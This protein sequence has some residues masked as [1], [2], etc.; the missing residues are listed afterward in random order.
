MT[1]RFSFIQELR[2]VIDRTY[3]RVEFA[4]DAAI[5]QVC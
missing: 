4:A 3:R 2:A 5:R 1:A